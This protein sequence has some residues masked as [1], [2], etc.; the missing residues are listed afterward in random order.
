MMSL[1]IVRSARSLQNL[2]IGTEEFHDSI[3]IH[4]HSQV[5]KEYDRARDAFEK[6][7]TGHSR[8]GSL[9]QSG[10]SLEKAAGRSL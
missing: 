8:Q 1:A 5:A 9:W 10:K 2:I 4:T 7:A 6:A 3:S